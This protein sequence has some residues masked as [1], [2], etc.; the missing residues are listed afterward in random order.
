GGYCFGGLVHRLSNT[1]NT[2]FALRTR[3]DDHRFFEF[4]LLRVAVL[5][6]DEAQLVVPDGD[7]VAVLHRM[8]LDQ[9]A[10]DIG[11]IG[12]VQV[13]QEGVVEYIDDQG[14]VAA[15]RRIID[16]Y[17]VIRE[18]PYGIALLVHVV[19]RKDLTV[20]AEHQTCHS[21]SI[22]LTKPSQYFVKYT[23]MRGEGLFNVR[24]DDRHIIPSAVIV[25]Q[26]Y[27]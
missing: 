12:T 9:L 18:P 25:R 2:L 7:D 3:R 19:F 13:L 1:A 23:P 15:D 6:V 22:S 10:V 14:V 4:V 16:P 8:F 27:Q 26:L 17:V 20:Q 24:H 21:D 5:V 11:A